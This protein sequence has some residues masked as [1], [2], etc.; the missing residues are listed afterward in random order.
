M[1]HTPLISPAVASRISELTVELDDLEVQLGYLADYTE[2]GPLFGLLRSLQDSAA[3][4]SG[5]LCSTLDDE[6]GENTVLGDAGPYFAPFTL[7][8]IARQLSAA[9]GMLAEA[10]KDRPRD[11]RLALEWLGLRMLQ[12]SDTANRI[13]RTVMAELPPCQPQALPPMVIATA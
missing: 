3:E 6:D 13:A 7:G 8:T 12:L 4:Y 11:A 1:S 9:P 2:P 10:G 5:S